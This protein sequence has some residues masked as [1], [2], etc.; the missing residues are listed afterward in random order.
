MHGSSSS[1]YLKC[2]FKTEMSEDKFRL[3]NEGDSLIEVYL[4][5]SQPTV[6]VRLGAKRTLRTTDQSAT[7]VLLQN[8]MKD[9]C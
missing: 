9:A 5:D 8:S 3:V 1:K 4:P 7:Y 6:V 2:K